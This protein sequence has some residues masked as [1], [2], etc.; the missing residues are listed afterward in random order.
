VKCV[1]DTVSNYLVRLIL[2]KRSTL[3]AA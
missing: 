1:D 3:C 2:P